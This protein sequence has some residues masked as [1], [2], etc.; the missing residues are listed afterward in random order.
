MVNSESVAGDWV[1]LL[2]ELFFPNSS[3][4]YVHQVS[5]VGRLKGSAFTFFR[6]ILSLCTWFAWGGL[7]VPVFFMFESV[8]IVGD[9]VPGTFAFPHEQVQ[10][11]CS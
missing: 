10:G 2:D 11:I 6:P 8:F 7:V 4:H 1:V 3:N 9:S 5:G